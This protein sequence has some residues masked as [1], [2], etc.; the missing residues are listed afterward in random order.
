MVPKIAKAG[1]SFKGAA[2]YYLHDKGAMTDDRVAFI[3]TENLPTDK[4]NIAVAHMIDTAAHA[5]ELKQAA[6]IKGGRNLQT[7]VYCYSLAWHTSENPT[8]EEQIAAAKETLKRLGLDSRQAI[9]IGHDDTDHKHVHVMVNRVCPET[10]RAANMGNDRLI[11]SDWALEYRKERG[12]EHFCPAREENQKRRKGEYVKDQSETRQEWTE[13]KKTQAKEL[14]DQFR[15]DKAKAKPAR[16]AQYDAL[17]RQKEERIAQRRNEIKA[18]FKP[19]WRDLFQRQKADLKNFDA[20]FFD[21]VGFAFRRKNRSKLGGLLQAITG[22]GNLRLEFIR[23]QKLER[24]QLG[25][26][27]K[28]TIA[29][30][31]REVTKA[32]KYDREHL[33]E[34]HQRQDQTAYEETKAK[35][36]AIWE[37]APRSASGQDFQNA[38]DRR[39]DDAGRKSFDERL[40]KV[41]GDE[42]VE[43]AKAEVRKRERKSRNRTRK[44]KDRDF[45][46]D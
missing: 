9:I 43:K 39:K 36:S 40:R 14:W 31:A 30:A 21:R 25:D 13:A 23:A 11:L 27:H 18:Y 4:S 17:W 6:G 29:D 16:Q 26:R 44:P 32:Y 12:E 19:Q 10:G 15:A 3:E 33:I 5:H 24:R 1:R 28:S 8:H 37:G 46:P 41:K 45:T 20:G 38:K 42:A 22:D 7:P 35:S 2:L 34:M